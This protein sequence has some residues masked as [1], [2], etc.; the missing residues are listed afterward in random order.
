MGCV[1]SFIFSCFFFAAKSLHELKCTTGVSLSTLS[2]EDHW[3]KSHQFSFANFS[4]H[5]LVGYSQQKVR[6]LA[7]MLGRRI[8]W[9]KRNKVNVW[10]LNK[11]QLFALQLLSKNPLHNATYFKVARTKGLEHSLQTTSDQGPG[12]KT[13]CGRSLQNEKAQVTCRPVFASKTFLEPG[14]KFVV[15]RHCQTF[16]T[17]QMKRCFLSPILHDHAHMGL[18]SHVWFYDTVQ[19]QFEMH[20]HWRRV[21]I[22]TV[23]ELTSDLNRYLVRVYK[24]RT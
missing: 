23:G 10:S 15:G 11:K 22:F 5:D 8:P 19:A 3:H 4:I 18:N 12:V 6:V 21:K 7:F 16:Q 9:P 14:T 17:G 2:C 13:Y 24:Y 1:E 20:M